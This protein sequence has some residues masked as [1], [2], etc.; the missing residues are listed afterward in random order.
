MNK[1]QK[2]SKYIKK[3]GTIILG[4]N[5]LLNPEEYQERK[6]IQVPRYN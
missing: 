2:E 3:L 5:N 4:C 6:I 1:T